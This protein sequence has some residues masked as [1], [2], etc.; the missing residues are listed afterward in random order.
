MFG[1]PFQS[2]QGGCTRAREVGG[3]QG[4]PPRLD[5]AGCA[6]RA[7]TGWQ[8]A[9][10]PEVCTVGGAQLRWALPKRAW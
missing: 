1:S 6:A 4:G 5:Q 2:S 10:C 9:G 7:V 8:A 3:S